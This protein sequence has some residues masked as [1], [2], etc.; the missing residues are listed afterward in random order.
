VSKI[1]QGEIEAEDGE[2]KGQKRKENA[3][4]GRKN[5]RAMLTWATDGIN[6]LP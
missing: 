4:E 3:A 6:D 2:E 5:L 1:D